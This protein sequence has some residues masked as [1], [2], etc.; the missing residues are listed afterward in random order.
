[1]KIKDV[2]FVTLVIAIIP[3]LLA[4]KENLQ[5]EKLTFFPV[6]NQETNQTFNT[7]NT[8]QAKYSK[9]DWQNNKHQ[10]IQA[11][12]DVWL[13]KDN[14]YIVK[15]ICKTSSFQ[16]LKLLEDKYRKYEHYSYCCYN[17]SSCN[18]HKHYHNRSQIFSN[19]QKRRVSF[20]V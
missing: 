4:N 10:N 5:L 20:D 12:I 16:Y 13:D 11:P 15:M 8:Y 18:R 17:N 2:F 14:D 6:V 19:H 9:Y 3:F 1:M 7:P